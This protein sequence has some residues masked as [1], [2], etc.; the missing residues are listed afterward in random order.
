MFNITHMC[1]CS[2]C[3][4]LRRRLPTARVWAGSSPKLCFTWISLYFSFKLEPTFEIQKIPHEILDVWLYVENG[5]PGQIVPAFIQ[6]GSQLLLSDSYPFSLKFTLNYDFVERTS[7]APF[8][9][10]NDLLGFFK[11]SLRLLL[12][13]V[14][15]RTKRHRLGPLRH[16]I[17]LG[18]WDI[19]I[20]QIKYDCKC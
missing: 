14:I 15:Q 3:S 1:I 12:G 5:S 8:S 17:S 6:G 11:L 16:I 13:D 19:N 4:L 20:G 9:C 7:L 18:S 2:C 10:L